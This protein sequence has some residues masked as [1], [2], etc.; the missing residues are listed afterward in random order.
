MT[1]YVALLQVKGGAGKST[2]AANLCGYFLAQ[3][4]SVLSVDADLPQ[5]TLSSWAS[6]TPV[7]EKHSHTTARTT[8]ELIKVLQ[9]AD[10]KHDIVLIDSPPRIAEMLKAILFIGDLV[11][12][13]LAATAPDI[14]STNDLLPIIEEAKKKKELNLH[15]VFNEYSPSQ[16]N[17]EIRQQ[18][19]DTLGIPALDSYLSKYVAYSEVMGLGKHVLTHNHQKAKAQFKALTQEVEKLLK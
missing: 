12:V 6:L 2:I 4:L 5:A 3:G 16:R 7:N 17:K 13:P 10:G 14:W 18:A 11:L 19:I 9:D 15:L 1:K 8:E